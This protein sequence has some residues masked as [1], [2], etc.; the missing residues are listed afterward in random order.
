MGGI[1]RILLVSRGFAWNSPLSR[2]G[3][4]TSVEAHIYLRFCSFCRQQNSTDS[5][6]LIP[7]FTG[8]CKFIVTR[9]W[10]KGVNPVDRSLELRSFASIFFPQSLFTVS[11]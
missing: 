11:D 9:T 2:N 10:Q 3:T 5:A 1:C 8:M 6:H 4:I 7:K